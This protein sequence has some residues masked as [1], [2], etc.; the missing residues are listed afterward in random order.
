MERRVKLY[1]DWQGDYG[2]IIVQTNVEDAR[3]GVAE[4]AVEK[5]GIETIELKW[6]R[7]PSA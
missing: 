5:L 2:D 1:K 7:E 6:G 4:Y 3:L